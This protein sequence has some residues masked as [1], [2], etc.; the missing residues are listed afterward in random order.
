MIKRILRTMRHKKITTLLHQARAFRNS[1]QSDQALAVLQKAERLSPNDNRILKEYVWLHI[2]QGHELDAA[3]LLSQ[4][5]T[6][7]IEQQV[8]NEKD[9]FMLHDLNLK[10]HRYEQ[11]L[12]HLDAALTHQKQQKR[13]SVKALYELYR[14]KKKRP[15][16][17]DLLK[18]LSTR[19]RPEM[20]QT[21]MRHALFEYSRDMQ[22][23]LDWTKEAID[24][25]P[26]EQL[27][28]DWVS[29]FHEGG[30]EGPLPSLFFEYCEVTG[31]R[32]LYSLGIGVHRYLL[33]RADPE[34]IRIMRHKRAR[35]RFL[36]YD[37]TPAIEKLY[38]RHSESSERSLLFYHH[39]AQNLADHVPALHG[40]T[41]TLRYDVHYYAYIEPEYRYRDDG[42][43]KDVMDALLQI[44]AV[45]VK[46]YSETAPL[47]LR[48]RNSYITSKR[49]VLQKSLE[50]FRDHPLIRA[51]PDLLQL[52]KWGEAHAESI[53]RTID[54]AVPVFSHGDFHGGNILNQ[55][56]RLIVIDWDAS[57]LMPAGFDLAAYAITVSNNDL[58]LPALDY[59]YDNSHLNRHY[60]KN[61]L[62]FLVACMMMLRLLP[63]LFKQ[64]RLSLQ[65]EAITNRI[66]TLQVIY[67]LVNRSQQS[68]AKESSSIQSF[69]K[70]S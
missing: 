57:G 12:I 7:Q 3:E 1:A 68:F 60:T 20:M 56:D 4:V 35:L 23:L 47:A 16:P 41:S 2:R 39:F 8:L 28:K 36:S 61:E 37:G 14:L 38:T 42:Y 6:N 62:I 59:Y 67:E 50:T 11:A 17:P 70:R 53:L 64:S 13:V 34:S 15:A 31:N 55:G 45:P 66:P 9:F 43:M 29:C 40:Y 24:E 5:I 54:Q 18:D 10:N 30:Y 32:D 44:H 63:A 33:G 52:F 25:G 48:D 27:D 58:F 21:D 26:C 65:D 69:E 49:T 19:Y 51:E 46:D 22:V